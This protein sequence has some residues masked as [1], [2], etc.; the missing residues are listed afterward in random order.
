MPKYNDTKIGNRT[1]TT[2]QASARQVPRKGGMEAAVSERD[3]PGGSAHD[4]RDQRVGRVRLPLAAILYLSF[5]CS[6]CT[7]CFFRQNLFYKEFFF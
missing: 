3:R 1:Q 4:V 6:V 5:N 2:G 7:L